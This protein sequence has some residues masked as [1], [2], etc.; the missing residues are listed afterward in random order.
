MKSKIFYESLSIHHADELFQILQSP[1]IYTYIPES[2]PVSL[3]ALEARY[4]ELVVGASNG[5]GEVWFNWVISDAK[6]REPI[7]QLQTTVKIS[8]ETAH[9]A[10]VIFPQF[11]GQGFAS[12]SL[13]WLMNEISSKYTLSQFEAEIDSRNT[14]SIRVVQNRGFVKSHIKKTSVGSDI[15]FIKKAL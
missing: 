13:D 5:S 8:E 1:E 10:Y 3:V 11:W 9:L 4:R 6:S 12:R 14:A 15:I 2:P 7:G